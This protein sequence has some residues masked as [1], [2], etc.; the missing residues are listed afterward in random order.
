MRR[1]RERHN[2]T[3]E[4]TV[5]NTDRH[6][7]REWKKWGCAATPGY[8]NKKKIRSRIFT[9][10]HMIYTSRKPL[11]HHQKHCNKFPCSAGGT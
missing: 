1:Y 7:T 5:A 6:G 11:C 8:Y 2:V 10:W 9:L 3:S 4:R